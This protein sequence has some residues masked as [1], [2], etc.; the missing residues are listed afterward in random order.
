MSQ[1][2]RYQYGLRELDKAIFNREKLAIE[3]SGIL[4]EIDKA[5]T[6]L[7]RIQDDII[8]LY[9]KL[10]ETA[11]RRGENEKLIQQLTPKP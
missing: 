7:L 3:Y 11:A 8:L 6:K 4:D 10:E 9:R 2:G 5:N 1:Y